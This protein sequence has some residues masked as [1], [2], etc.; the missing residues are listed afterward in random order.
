MKS[1][2]YIKPHQVEIRNLP[3]PSV[4]PGDL[5]LRV[6]AC[7]V[8]G[9]DLRK[10]R[11]DLVK[12]PTVLGHEVAGEVEAMGENASGF[13]IGDRVAGVRGR[14]LRFATTAGPEERYPAIVGK[15]YVFGGGRYETQLELER[16]SVRV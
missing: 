15:R 13:S 4:E 3:Q 2:V 14:D 5:L 9:T 6:R 11:H 12:P 1:A 16:T 10:I 7:G 8:C